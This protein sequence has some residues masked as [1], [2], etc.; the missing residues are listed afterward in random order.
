MAR[1]DAFDELVESVPQ[2]RQIK[3]QKM[4]ILT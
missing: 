1:A 4:T 3:F 2:Y